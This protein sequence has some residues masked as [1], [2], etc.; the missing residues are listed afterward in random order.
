MNDPFTSFSVPV[1]PMLLHALGASDPKPL[2]DWLT[3]HELTVWHAA[4]LAAEG[5]APYAFYLIRRTELL[6]HLSSD[7]QIA[8][9]RSYLHSIGHGLMM[10]NEAIRWAALFDGESITAIWLKGVPLALTVYPEIGLRPMAD[11]DVL[12]PTHQ[13]TSALA[14]LEQKTGRKPAHLALDIE[15]RAQ[16][17]PR[18]QVKM[19]LHWDLLPR[20]GRQ[21]QARSTDIGWFFNQTLSIKTEK[22]TLLG[23][24][25]AAH[26]LYLCTHLEVAHHGQLQLRQYFDLHRLVTQT[27]DLDWDLVVERAVVEGWTQA[28]ARALRLSQDLFATPLP[29]GLLEQL[30]RRRRH[31]EPVLMTIGR[32]RGDNRWQQ[33]MRHLSVMGW[34]E[35]LAAI[36]ALVF[37]SP[38]YMRWRYRTARDWQLPL[39]YFYRWWDVGREALRT[40]GAQAGFRE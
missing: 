26:L 22:G 36:L 35:R 19:D 28:V 18:G 34:N 39:Y 6:A 16:V 14:L 7:V 5:L 3:A 15:A 29:A 2:A 38:A 30:H 20:L 8:L 33:T 23:L 11:I 13:V 4:W 12:V 9:R 1:D 25:P 32:T 10:V 17:G 40:L 24:R 21:R 31:D 27:P 37:P